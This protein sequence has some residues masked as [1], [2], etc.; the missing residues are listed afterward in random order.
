V[1]KDVW[2][3]LGSAYVPFRACLSSVLTS[4]N[5]MSVR[6]LMEVRFFV[7]DFRRTPLTEMTGNGKNTS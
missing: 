3:L 7:G 1:A 5:S 2:G 6:S 4:F